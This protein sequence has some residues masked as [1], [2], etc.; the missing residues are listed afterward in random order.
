MM[1]FVIVVMFAADHCESDTLCHI[2][3]FS[4]IFAHNVVILFYCIICFS[5]L[6]FIVQLRPGN[7]M[8]K[9]I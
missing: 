4:L 1:G 7:S 3:K 8:I 9:I 6:Y 2:Y 5:I